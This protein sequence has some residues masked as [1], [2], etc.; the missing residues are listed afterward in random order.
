VDAAFVLLTAATAQFLLL[1]YVLMFLAAIVLKFKDPS[2][3]S[4]YKIPFGALG[5]CAIAGPGLLVCALFYAIGFFPPDGIAC[6]NGT[7]YFLIIL[8]IN[9]VIGLLPCA[10][11][12]GNPRKNGTH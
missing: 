9:I 4:P 5:T 8:A 1:M 3:S 2:A 10:L 11:H 7:A 12:F 6:G